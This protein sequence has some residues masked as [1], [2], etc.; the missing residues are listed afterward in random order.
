ME[1]SLVSS[2]SHSERSV[3]GLCGSMKEVKGF[4][5]LYLAH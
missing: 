3:V 1:M 2:V 5:N 4:S